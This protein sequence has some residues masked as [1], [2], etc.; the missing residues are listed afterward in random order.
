MSFTIVRT[1]GTVLTVI[2]DGDLNTTSTPLFLPG[3]NY[4]GYGA[5]IDTNFVRALENFAFTNPPDNPLQ[6]QLW[7]NTR[8][9]FEGLYICP[10]DGETN[11]NNW[12]KIFTTNDIN[13]D[14]FAR[15]LTL[16][17]DL[18]AN[19]AYI[20]NNVEANVVD[21]DY[22]TVR[23]QANI[24][25]A[26]ITGLTEVANLQTANITAGSSTTEA[27]LAGSWTLDGTLT[28]LGNV[29]ALGVIT[30]NYRYANGEL[31]NF[32]QAAGSNSQVQYNLNGNLAASSKLTF[33]DSGA[34][35]NVDGSI[36]SINFET[37]GGTFT[38]N[39]AGLSSI[40]ASNVIGTLPNTVQSNITQLGVLSALTVTNTINTANIFAS[41]NVTATRLTGSLVTPAQPN[42]TS[43]G[44]LSSLTVLSFIN[45]GT[46]S[47]TLLG[48]GGNISN[49]RGSNVVGEVSS[50]AVAN[51]VSVSNV[52]GIGNVALLNLNSNSNTVLYG[53]GV[54]A[55]L[56]A[57]PTPYGNSNVVTL[58]SSFGSNSIST[59][60]D[61]D[62]GNIDATLVTATLLTGTLTNN[63][64]PNITSVG[65]LSSLA[66]NGNITS[67]NVTAN[68]IG[69]GS[70]LSSITGAN[71]TGTVANATYA[72]SAGSATT[73]G[74]VT[75]AVQS[76]ITSVGTLNS[77][78]V[79]GN[80][81][82]GN[83]AATGNTNFSQGT[84][85]VR[86]IIEQVA[87]N[88]SGITG[89]VNV[90]LI[91]PSTKYYTSNSTGNFILNFRGNS[92]VTATSYLS[93]GRSAKT[94]ILVKQGSTPYYPNGFTI[95]S[96]P[97]T[98][99]WLDG[100]IPSA[101]TPN[102]IN[103]YTFNIIKTGST[104]YSVFGAV[105]MYSESSPVPTNVTRTCIAVID[106]CSVNASTISSDWTIFR[107]TWPQRPFYLLQP[108]G[109]S[110][111]SLNQPA[112]FTAD[113][114]AFGPITVNRDNGNPSQA[115][116]WYALCNLAALPNGSN[117][118]L[119]IDNSGSMTTA[120]VQASVDLLN[121]QCALR[122]LTYALQTDAGENWVLPFNKGL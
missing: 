43:V 105:A 111:G 68:H 79:S 93:T 73:A 112:S 80:L 27:S 29:T 40:P 30:D 20:S 5:V 61:I 38:G 59:T 88:S 9:G 22:L 90:D 4:P 25:N 75:A 51:S 15:S 41:N 23:I 52:S 36:K 117:F 60:G 53:N 10:I 94:T 46:V 39:A 104:S 31:I 103:E 33:S 70:Q 35:L 113:P 44:T 2:P 83:I 106:E 101:G 99:N 114:K 50:A 8:P 98:I 81:T 58:L 96:T 32:E 108:G 119:W 17:D 47:G 49:I 14:L 42:I 71:V 89:V 92:S 78:N 67:L 64:Q 13:A 85:Q 48:E 16:T 121:A 95:D 6:G 28:S 45:A 19:N 107:Q 21:T 120:T 56:P 100:A 91:G 24:A 55:S 76:N 86:D 37:N 72:T 34:L 66:V 18:Y 110:Q 65:V 63:S 109:P 62:A 7:Y 115:S 54:F 57:P 116:D 26:N 118:A 12:I 11:P 3:R 97:V 77:L 82:G 122:G 69:N 84:Q 102:S 74:T 87:L 1:N